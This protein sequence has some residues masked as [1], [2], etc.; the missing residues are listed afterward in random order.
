MHG[1][2]QVRHVLKVTFG[3]DHLLQVIG[4]GSI[5]L[6]FVGGI[7]DDPFF[8][9]RTDLPCVDPQSNAVLFA[10]VPEDGLLIGAGGILAQRPYTAIGI[11]ADEVIGEELDHGRGNHIEEGFD[12]DLLSLGND[13]L[14][15]FLFQ[16]DTS[17]CSFMPELSSGT[18]PSTF[19]LTQYSTSGF[20][21]NSSG[22]IQKSSIWFV[23]SSSS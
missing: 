7:V 21:S 20:S 10:Q 22:W 15:L 1:G 5:H 8:L 4:V 13:R 17:Y 14:N 18:R 11:A 19:T 23:I 2:N 16:C 3:S 9:C 6:V 12:L